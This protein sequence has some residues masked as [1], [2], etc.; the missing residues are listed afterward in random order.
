LRRFILYELGSLVMFSAVFMPP[1]I[2]AR[3]IGVGPCRGR[4]VATCL[5]RWR[6]LPLRS[7]TRRWYL[8]PRSPMLPMAKFHSTKAT[9][10]FFRLDTDIPESRSTR[11]W[12]WICWIRNLSGVAETWWDAGG[13]CACPDTDSFSARYQNREGHSLLA[14][15]T[16]AFLHVLVLLAAGSALCYGESINLN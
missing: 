7:Q 10:R 11:T 16:A 9:R 5:K 3:N 8:A 13:I 12:G 2:A 15:H 1:A 14:I 4:R 6:A